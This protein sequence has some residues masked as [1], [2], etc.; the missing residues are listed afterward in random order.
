[1]FDLLERSD[2]VE[3]ASCTHQI[4]LHRVSQGDQTMVEYTVDFS[5]DAD[6]QICQDTR[7]KRQAELK[8]MQHYFGKV[9]VTA[10]D[11]DW[12]RHEL[13]QLPLAQVTVTDCCL[14]LLLYSLLFCSQAFRSLHQSFVDSPQSH[15]LIRIFVWLIK[16]P[17]IDL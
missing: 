3:V 6:A 2:G 15:H 1:M 13:E 11:P 5:N 4:A 17:K 8:A 7:F 9:A 14:T 12:I 16:G 10:E